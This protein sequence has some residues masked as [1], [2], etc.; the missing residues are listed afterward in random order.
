MGIP[1]SFAFRVY[2]RLLFGLVNSYLHLRQGDCEATLSLFYKHVL[3]SFTLGNTQGPFIKD[4]HF[5]DLPSFIS[6]FI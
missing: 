5:N 4:F 3:T 1:F 6:E 2:E